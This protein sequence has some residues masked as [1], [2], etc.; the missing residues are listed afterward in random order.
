LPEAVILLRNGQTEKILLEE[1]KLSTATP[2]AN[3]IVRNTPSA[4]NILPPTNTTKPEEL[5]AE[6]QRQ[7][8]SNPESLLQLVKVAPFYENNR[9]LG[10]R[11]MPGKDANAMAKFNLQSGDILTAVNGVTLDA[12]LNDLN[13]LPKL[14]TAD[15]ISLQLLRNGQSLSLNFAIRK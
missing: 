2:P 15:Q 14:A 6:Y 9:F 5:L 11:L 10:Y 4:P 13:L 12:S 1:K 8:Q 3:L 7:L